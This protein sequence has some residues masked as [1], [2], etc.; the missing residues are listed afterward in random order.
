M[1]HMT[2]GENIDK[3]VLVKVRVKTYHDDNAILRIGLAGSVIVAGDTPCYPLPTEPAS[4]NVFIAHIQ[5][6]LPHDAEVICK[7]CGK[8]AKATDSYLK[9]DSFD[10]DFNMLFDGQPEKVRRERREKLIAALDVIISSAPKP[11]RQGPQP[12][13]RQ[14]QS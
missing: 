6:H 12:R 8:T 13:R 10:E 4:D 14:G 9:A 1:K 2:V 5:A 11:R 7:I 3:D